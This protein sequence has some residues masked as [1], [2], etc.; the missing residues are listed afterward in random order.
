MGQ[1]RKTFSRNSGRSFRTSTFH[2]ILSENIPNVG[3]PHTKTLG[4]E[5]GV[6]ISLG[7]CLSADIFTPRRHHTM[8]FGMIKIGQSATQHGEQA[9][10]SIPFRDDR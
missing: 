6:V 2:L 10:S 4:A 3:M 7:G 9:E 5:F 1:E 8:Y